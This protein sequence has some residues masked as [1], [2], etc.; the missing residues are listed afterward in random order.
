MNSV[1]EGFFSRL[2]KILIFIFVGFVLFGSYYIFQ[3][4]GLKYAESMELAQLAR[5][6]SIGRGYVT[7]CIRPVDIWYLSDMPSYA[8][9]AQSC[10]DIRNPP[11][12]PSI[13]S[14]AFKV[15]KPAFTLKPGSLSFEPETKVIIPLCILF[16]LMTGMFI[17]LVGV[18]LFGWRVAV[19][20]VLVFFLSKSVLDESISGLPSSLLMLLVSAVICAALSFREAYEGNKPV[21]FMVL[22]FF[23]AAMLSAAIFLTSYKMS[24]FIPLLAFFMVSGF[25][26]RSWHVAGAFLLVVLIIISPWLVR[27]LK[28]SGNIAGIAHYSALYETAL[29]KNYS[30]DHECS[31]TMNNTKIA[32]ALKQKFMTTFPEMCETGLRTIGNGLIICLF[33]V[34]VFNK[35]EREEVN[36]LKWSL[37]VMLLLVAAAGAIFPAGNSNVFI[38]FLPLVILYGVAFFFSII[39]RDE[40]A[41]PAWKITFAAVLV[42]LSALPLVFAFSS[43]RV[44]SPYPPYYPPFISYVSNLLTHEETICTDIPWATAWYGNRNSILLPATIDEFKKINEG[45]ARMAGLYLTTVTGDM[46]FNSTFVAGPMRSWLPVLNGNVPKDFPLMHGITL[47]EGR[48]DQLF[49]TDKDRWARPS[50][51]AGS[52]SGSS[53]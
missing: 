1:T 13:V 36:H 14:M 23:I 21:R 10:P 27:N 15:V 41:D 25:L 20:G 8:F 26:R 43:R 17:Y 34:S 6:I 5:N 30:F 39:D 53:K 3:F 19:V 28:V 52:A 51:G 2:M 42:L 12:F 33:L 49:L 29:Y 47:P 50:V 46:P 24:V 11:F 37:L 9:Q 4:R 35:Y 7:S 38:P 18:K 44:A 48:N 16:T 45:K 22:L 31:P 32:R 40:F